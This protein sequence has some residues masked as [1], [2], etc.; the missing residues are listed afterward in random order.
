EQ[1]AWH[2]LRLDKLIAAADPVVSD[3][4]LAA[5]PLN[6]PV[7]IASRRNVREKDRVLLPHRLPISAVIVGRVEVVAIYPPRFVEHLIPLGARV[8]V[9]FNRIGIDLT[10]SELRLRRD[11]YNSPRVAGN[12]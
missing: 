3:P 4:K 11:R 12:V 1:P 5:H 9:N 7:Q 8:D 10:G 2:T 6:H